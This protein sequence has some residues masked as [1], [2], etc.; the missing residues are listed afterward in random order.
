MNKIAVI[1]LVLI[2]GFISCDTFIWQEEIK[3]G[4]VW[5]W[6]REHDNPW[7][8]PKITDY[9]VLAIKDGWVKYKYPHWQNGRYSTLKVRAFRHE[10]K[11]LKEE[12][13]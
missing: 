13:E 6:E 9:E 10:S 5:R 12:T 7:E 1:C 4:Q 3:P 2:F 11:L 8:K